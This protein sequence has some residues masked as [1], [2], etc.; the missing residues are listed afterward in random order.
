MIDLGCEDTRCGRPICSRLAWR[1]R[2]AAAAAR[3]KR[4]DRGGGHRRAGRAV[5]RHA[6]H[7]HADRYQPAARACAM[8][9]R[10]AARSCL[11]RAGHAQ[12]RDRLRRLRA[13]GAA[14]GA[15]LLGGRRAADPHPRH[16]RRQPGHRL[17]RQRHDHAA[18][19]ARRATSCWPASRASA[20]CR[21]A[22]SISAC[23]AP[24][25][26]PDELMREIR[27]PA[28]VP[29]QR[30]LFLKLG[31]R[32]AQAISVINLAIVLTFDGELVREARDRPGLR[33]AHRSC[34][35]RAPRRIWQGKH[36]RRRDLRRGRAA[37]LRRLSR[38]S[39]TC[40][41]RPPTACTPLA[42]LVATGCERL[43]TAAGGAGWAEPP[44]AARHR[45]PQP[46]TGAP[47]D[48]T[49]ATTINGAP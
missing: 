48:G 1:R 11:G 49:I 21:C 36:A 9:A 39:T 7:R 31:L 29:H 38:R 47:F 37:G 24:C 20:S 27:F 13:P 19:G 45:R 34:A 44:G 43:A 18:A 8:C 14:A 32:R 2:C 3:R 16:R 10:R 35:R 30:G 42:A 17:A 4:A 26:R 46:A 40:A 15:G 25:S 41:A 6:P 23:A 33:R 22:T 28:L 5:A 12:R